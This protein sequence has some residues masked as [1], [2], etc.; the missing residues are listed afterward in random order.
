MNQVFISDPDFLLNA[1]T[2]HVLSLP[3]GE[4]QVAIQAIHV[5]LCNYPQWREQKLSLERMVLSQHITM[6]EEQLKQ[7]NEKNEKHCLHIA[8]QERQ[9]AEQGRRIDE[10]DQQIAQQGQQ[11]AQQGQRIAEL[12]APASEKMQRINRVKMLFLKDRN[13]PYTED[14][15][16]KVKETQRLSSYLKAHKLSSRKLNSQQDDIL[17]EIIVAFLRR[18]CDRGLIATQPSGAAIFRFLTTDVQLGTELDEKTYGNK[19]RRLMENLDIPA[20]TEIEVGKAF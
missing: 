12:E 5:V 19:I 3:F 16:V 11:I 17:N 10:K 6:L 8:E 14:T 13:D 9:I 18:W 4:A 1:V 15:P 2:E 20:A 7:S